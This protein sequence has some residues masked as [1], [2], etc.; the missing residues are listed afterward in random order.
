MK[1]TVVGLGKLGLCMAGVFAEAGHDVVGVDVNAELVEALR[2]GNCPIQEL[3]LKELLHKTHEHLQ[4]TTGFDDTRNFEPAFVIVPTPSGEDH[5]FRNDY[6]FEAVKKLLPSLSSPFPTIAITSTVMPGTMDEIKKMIENSTGKDFGLAYNPEFVALGNVIQGMKFPDA[7]LIGESDKRSGDVLESFYKTI[8]LKNPPVH[9]MSFWNAELSKIAL[10]T[11]VTTKISLAN[12]IA[13]ICG[14]MPTGDVDVV[15]D[16]LGADSRVGKKYLRGGLGFMGPCFPRD[17]RAFGTLGITPIQEAVDVFNTSHTEYVLTHISRLVE[18]HRPST[19][20]ILGLTYKPDTP[21]V[22]ESQSLEIAR[23]LAADGHFVRLY[24]PQGMPNAKK[25]LPEGKSVH[26]ASNTTECL[27]D[28]D[29]C[30]LATMWKEF[31]D[32]S[33]TWFTQQMRHPVVYD[34]WRF[35]N[36]ELFVEYGI[37][38]HALGVNSD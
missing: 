31:S 16:F 17:Q 21:V 10:N 7:I 38:Y 23:R 24:D 34:C 25:M 14:E 1:V 29:L 4:Y 2:R 22:E 19:I 13:E 6:V 12:T 11:Y 15:T 32:P 33:P 5:R 30:V 35:W 36:R 9:R 8:C 28:S 18:D 27:H 26:Y 20:S 3:G 37:E